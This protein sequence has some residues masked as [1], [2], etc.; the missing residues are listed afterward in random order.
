MKAPSVGPRGQAMLETAMTMPLTVFVFLGVIQM[1]LLAQGR[2]MVKY[3]AYRAARAGALHNACGPNAS[4]DDKMTPAALSAL[5]PVISQGD[6]LLQAK[7]IGTYS[8]SYMTTILNRYVDALPIVDVRIC[9]PIQRFEQDPSTFGPQGDTNQEIDFDYFANTEAGSGG[10]VNQ[11][12][13]FERTRLR[14]QVKFNQ[15]LIIPFANAIIFRIWDLQQSYASLMTGGMYKH[16]FWMGQGYSSSL[17]VGQGGGGNSQRGVPTAED[18]MMLH[19]LSYIGHYY[20]PI[21]G[22]YAFRMQSNFFMSA[23]PLPTENKCFHY[24]DPSDSS[25]GKP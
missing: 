17:D 8:T 24:N 18:P 19:F 10:P 21:Y 23:C 7:D 14:V 1:A 25:A 15:R 20:L 11:V 6:F 16:D 5:V 9:G 22:N 3:A 13:N 2:A 4:S 12:E